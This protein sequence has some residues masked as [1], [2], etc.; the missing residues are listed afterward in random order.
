MCPNA[1]TCRPLLVRYLI[2]RDLDCDEDLAAAEIVKCSLLMQHCPYDSSKVQVKLHQVVHEGLK[3]YLIDKYS[4]E[5]IAELILLYIETLTTSAQH[6]DLNFHMTSKMMAP[7]FK[8]LCHRP[9]QLWEL[10]L[11]KT[12]IRNALQVTFFN[13]ENICRKHYFLLEAGRYFQYSLRIRLKMTDSDD[14]NKI[15]FIATVLNSQ[16]LIFHEN[17]EYERAELYL[18]RALETLKA[19]H[20]PNTSLPEIADS[21]N[22]LVILYYTFSYKVIT[23][24]EHEKRDYVLQQYGLHHYTLATRYQRILKGGGGGTSPIF[25]PI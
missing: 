18:N 12:S 21:V 17:G 24:M 19:L 23:K 22:K 20:P 1:C 5:Q 13:F 14:K 15:R 16:G 11:V 6:F 10:V 4:E 2:E 7:R 9:F 25:Q 8:T 3:K